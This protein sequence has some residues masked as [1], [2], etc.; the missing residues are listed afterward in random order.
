MVVGSIVTVVG[1]VVGLDDIFSDEG[2]V[3]V[4]SVSVDS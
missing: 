3:V 1:A 2:L 4:A